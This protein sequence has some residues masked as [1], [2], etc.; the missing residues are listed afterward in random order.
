MSSSYLLPAG[1][2]ALIGTATVLHAQRDMPAATG[3]SG[4]RMLSATIRIVGAVAWPLVLFSVVP[5]ADHRNNLLMIPLMWNF[6]VWCV[7]SYLL[8]NSISNDDTR[9]AGLRVDPTNMA[10]LAFGLSNLCGSRPDGKYTSLFMMAVLGIVIM[11]LPSHNLK[12]G[13]VE[14]L[15]F[16]NVQKIAISWCVGIIITAVL[17]SRNTVAANQIR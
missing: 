10:G 6:L 17:L 7:D 3:M 16:D 14:E 12:A 5:V 1:V 8:H 9:P 11:V 15:T 13:T 2:V 4:Q